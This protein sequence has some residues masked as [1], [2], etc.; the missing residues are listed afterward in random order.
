MSHPHRAGFTASTATE[1]KSIGDMETYDPDEV[2]DY[3]QMKISKIGMSKVVSI[4][5]KRHPDGSSQV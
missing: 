3:P 5:K 4:T 2:L 1:I